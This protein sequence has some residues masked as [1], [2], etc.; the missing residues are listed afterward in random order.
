MAKEGVGV[1]TE[2]NPSSNALIDAARLW[3][4]AGYCVVPS[5]EDGGKRPFG[6]WK[7]YQETRLP[8]DNLVGL[9]ATGKYTGIGVICGASSGNAELLEIE[10]PAA[11]AVDRL[12]RIIEHAKSYNDPY[13]ND[14]VN[15]VT[16][17]CVEKSA[18]GGIHFFVRI[19]DGPA[20]GNTKLAYV[21]DPTADT[22]KKVICETRGHKGFVIV[23]PTPARN[24]H[25]E[26]AA[27]IFAR[28]TTPAG[29]PEISSDDRD[30]LHFLFARID[31]TADMEEPTAPE[32]K[33]DTATSPAIDGTSTFDAF[34]AV[35]WRDILEPLGWTWSHSD[36]TRDYWT[37]PGKNKKDGPSAS[38]IEDGPL[39][40]FS[41]NSGL[42]TERGMSKADVYAH[43]HHGGDPSAA[44]R[45][46]REQ[47]YGDSG[48]A[49]L[50]EF[51]F[52]PNTELTE[53]EQEEE[54][55]AWLARIH[56]AFP[57]IDWAE[58]WA[59]E[60]EEEWIVEPLLAA[61]RLVA[62]YSAPKVGK[63]LLMLEIAAAVANGRAMFGYPA[64]KPRRTLYVDFENDPRG[65]V[66]TR[67]IDMGYEAAELDNLVLL[68]FPTL[69][70]LDSKKGSEELLAII[71]AYQCEIVVIDTVSR[72]VEGDENEND[73]WL[74]FYRNTGLKLKQEQVALIRL[75]HSGKDESKGQR[76]GSA[77]SGDVDAVWRMSKDGEDLITLKCEANRF[78]ITEK[79]LTLQRL[80]G[81]LRHEVI[82]NAYQEKRDR[83]IAALAEAGVTKDRDMPL[84]DARKA[85]RE[86]KVAFKN[87]AFTAEL[88]ERY[89]ST[90]TAWTPT[91]IVGTGTETDPENGSK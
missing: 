58:L 62:L 38:T 60:T 40:N 3:Y 86:A 34:R 36:A 20:L 1:M 39:F 73:T 30:V 13:I 18:G 7:Q 80:E 74:A 75:D 35:P 57:R 66:R 5:H 65:D 15:R 47:G 72:S 61:R 85:A 4:D 2:T 25:P 78:P 77:K 83:L 71:R 69:S 19:T 29:T 24:G 82:G 10:G 14:L 84:R 21:P 37:R 87:G 54:R 42:P 26:G 70:A 8:W 43:Y 22:G 48:H 63:S 6:E 11:D 64:H 27:Y 56:E 90:P 46:L 81:P 50:N 53:E 59:D 76:G 12:G 68:S 88:W 33:K 16:R 9:L 79:E 49:R 31:E 52:T 67:L 55:A 41:S 17:G 91:T 23:A 45:A 32:R 28:G 51:I 44:A 89:C